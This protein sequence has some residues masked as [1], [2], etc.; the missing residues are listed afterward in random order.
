MSKLTIP[1]VRITNHYCTAV[2]R[3]SG[4]DRYRED[5]RKPWCHGFPSQSAYKH[6]VSRNILLSK[7]LCRHDD[8]PGLRVVSPDCAINVDQSI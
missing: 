4:F 1:V 8:N 7:L 6:Q 3:I 5:T 2:E